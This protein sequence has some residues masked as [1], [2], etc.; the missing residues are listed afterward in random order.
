[1]RNL[2]NLEYLDLYGNDNLQ[3]PNGCPTDEY[4]DM[5]YD[6]KEKVAAFLCCLSNSVLDEGQ[7]DEHPQRV[8]TSE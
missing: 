5:F 8:V 4:G 6:S 2:T 1:M 3:K 7:S